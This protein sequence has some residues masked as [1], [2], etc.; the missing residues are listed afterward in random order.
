MPHCPSC[1]KSGFVTHNAISRHMSQSRSSCSTW[2]NGLIHI[3][4]DLSMDPD[5]SNH[6]YTTHEQLGQGIVDEFGSCQ[7]DGDEE[8]L[9]MADEDDSESNPIEYFP[10]AAQAF[11][12]SSTF[13]NK[14][15]ADEFSNHRSSNI[16]YPFAPRGDWQMGSWL[17]C[18]GLSMSTINTFLSLDLVYFFV[19]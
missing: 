11:Q 1:G 4:K 15:A 2:S 16:Y 9:G 17:L 14:F 12:G 7:V 8:M 3:H 13:L 10:G 18:S 19:D 5:G 6:H